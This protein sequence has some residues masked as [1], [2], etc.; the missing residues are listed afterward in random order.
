[1]LIVKKLKPSR[2][3]NEKGMAII[4]TLPLLII[5]MVLLSFGIG[6]FGVVHTAIMNS[7]ASRA[8]AFETFRNRS[9]LRLFRDRKAD[10]ILT[11]YVNMGN[12]FHT[13]DSEKQIGKGL[14]DG[15]YATTR[16]LAI[17]RK[18][19]DSSANESDHNLKIYDLQPRNRKGGVEASP[20]WIM[21][22]YGIC[23]TP[24]CGD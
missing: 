14:G 13:V 2:L 12:R 15:Q 1:M 20:A 7:M 23:M 19:A 22:G 8:Y 17:G 5:F 6:L 21:V 16:P 11:H 9:D 4:E 18:V 10:G 3:K 24:R